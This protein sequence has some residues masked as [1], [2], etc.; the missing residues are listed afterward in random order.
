[1]RNLSRRSILGGAA[2]LPLIATPA[3]A[4]GITTMATPD[5]AAWDVAMSAFLAARKAHGD[6]DDGPIA[7]AE[8]RHRAVRQPEP[9]CAA[10][11]TTDEMPNTDEAVRRWGYKS[12][13]QV[14][15]SAQLSSIFGDKARELLARYEAWQKEDWAIQER[16]GLTAEQR[17]SD[18]LYAE[19]R[20]ALDRLLDMPAPDVVA[21]LFKWEQQQLYRLDEWD[22]AIS[23]DLRR[24]AGKEVARG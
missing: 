20:R 9:E 6:H 13:A 12:W 14:R 23:A 24:L 22:D 21:V 18:S 1:M 5:H 16:V 19:M 10:Y 3:L 17:I 11:F 7:A 4:Q 15:R 2:A 8:R